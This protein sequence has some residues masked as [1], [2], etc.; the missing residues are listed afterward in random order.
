M[1]RREQDDRIKLIC[2]HRVKAQKLK[3][4][5]L[6]WCSLC[7]R[8]LFTGWPEHMEERAKR[9]DQMKQA[10]NQYLDDCIENGVE[11]RLSA[12]VSACESIATSAAFAKCY[13]VG[14]A[15]DAD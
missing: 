14:G 3:D 15:V 11:P 4:S 7:K 9:A 2:G 8:E 5:D 10:V 6:A 12:I 13:R 1:S